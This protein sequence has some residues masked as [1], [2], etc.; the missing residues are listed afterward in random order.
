MRRDGAVPI[1]DGGSD[2]RARRVRSDAKISVA[3]MQ[4]PGF[5]WKMAQ[6]R[7]EAVELVDAFADGSLYRLPRLPFV[8][9][10][11]GTR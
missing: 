7:G 5:G 9:V 2:A 1:G 3:T 11:G 8:Y 10:V 6:Q 4:K